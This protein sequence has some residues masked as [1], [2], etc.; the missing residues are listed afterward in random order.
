M[1]PAEAHAE[2]PEAKEQGQFIR[3]CLVIVPLLV[4][5]LAI[6]GFIFALKKSDI[7]QVSQTLVATAFKG[8]SAMFDSALTDDE[9]EAAIRR[10]ALEIFTFT[11][12]LTW[13]LVL[14]LLAAGAPILLAD[15]L[16]LASISEVVGLMLRL[17]YILGVS[18][19]VLGF[20]F[21]AR[22]SR[23]QEDVGHAE[24][25]AYGAA[26]KIVHTLAF[27]TPGLM[28]T[29]ARID[30]RA[31]EITGGTHNRPPP[32]FITSLARGGTTALLNALHDMPSVATHTYSDMPFITAP[33]LWSKWGGNRSQRVARRERAHRDGLEIDL[34]SPEAFEEVLWRLYWP[35]KYRSESIPLWQG[36]DRNAGSINRLRTHF[37]KIVELRRK[38]STTSGPDRYVSKN[39]SNIGR[40][41]VL[42]EFYPQCKIIIPLRRPAAHAASLLRQHKRFTDLQ[43]ADD[44]VRRY[45]FDIGHDEFGLIHR[46]IAFETFDPGHLNLDQPDYWLKYWMAAFNEV[47]E[48]GFDGYIVTQDALRS[49]PNKTMNA[50]CTELDLEPEE[51]DFRGYFRT[52]P[53]LEPV[54][55]FSDVLYRNANALYDELCKRAISG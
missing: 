41:R 39:N 20:Y 14:A 4:S 38:H 22:R 46:P 12:K 54:E 45:M 34:N 6:P 40:L 35:E 8:V 11:W 21:V 10:S 26:D 15:A 48:H 18:V 25:E 47:K 7:A 31:F 23:K 43:K 19:L 52:E 27:A 29:L 53:D 49:Q 33:Y 5:L 28:R 51:M 36:S 32:I 55:L 1:V 9:K 30:D 2:V 24:D 16:G 17:D 50:L 37:D 44:F 13:R 42:Q 3:L